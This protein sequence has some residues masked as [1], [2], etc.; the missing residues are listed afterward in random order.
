MLRLIIDGFLIYYGRFTNHFV[1]AK[2]TLKQTAQLL[3]LE[4]QD[5]KRGQL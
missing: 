5:F 4:T 1:V 2:Q 3:F